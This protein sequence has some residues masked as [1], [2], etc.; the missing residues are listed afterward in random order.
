[1]RRT[2]YQLSAFITLAAISGQILHAKDKQ[3]K[4]KPPQAQDQIMVESHIAAANGPI[5]RFVATRHY[6][7]SYVYAE[8]APGQ[9]VTIIDVTNPSRPQIVSQ[10]ALP[11]SSANLFA[12]AGTSAL[13]GNAES[14][15]PSAP[16]TIRIMDFADPANPKVTRQFDNVTAI[17][18]VP[19]KLILL[20][21]TDG[22]F[23]LSQHLSDDP[24]EEE[25]YAR[26][27]V[28]G[29]SMY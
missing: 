21:N 14:A 25:R 28:Y 12:V 1:M 5:I 9:P 4:V 18:N 10:A 24:A 3:S 2:T 26:K 17:E 23:I 20:A 19:G 11:P 29:E 27:V 16:Q 22:I 13:T 7:R 6:N 8:R 15:K